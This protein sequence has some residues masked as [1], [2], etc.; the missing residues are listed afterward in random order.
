MVN[1]APFGCHCDIRNFEHD[2]FGFLIFD[3]LIVLTLKSMKMICFQRSELYVLL[4]RYY[5]SDTSWP[6]L[7][8]DLT[9]LIDINC[10]SDQ[11]KRC[12]RHSRRC[13]SYEFCEHFL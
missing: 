2:L 7:V 12:T 9:N 5:G 10:Q 8:L 13:T 4:Q 1:S 11:A 3:G 6:K